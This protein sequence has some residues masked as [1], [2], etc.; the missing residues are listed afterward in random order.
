MP[1]FAGAVT[2]V[3][4]PGV[5]K[6][7]SGKVRE[8]FD[9]GSRLLMVA[10]DRVSAFDVVM[11]NGIP[12][13]GKVLNQLS[14]FWFQ[15]L[16]DICPNHMISVDDREIERAVGQSYSTAL[17]GRSMLVERGTPLPI[18]CVAR[19]YIA[20]SLYK[21]YL[22]AG[23]VDREVQVHG[24]G[25]PKG[26]L[27]G[28][29]LPKPVFTPATKAVEGHDENISQEQAAEIVGGEIAADCEA[30]TLRLFAAAS[31]VCES[32]G[33]L[34]A[35]TKFEFSSTGSDRAVGRLM[36]IDEALTPDSS[37]FWP[38]ATYAPGR[39]QESLDKQFIRDYLEGL[40]WDKTPPGPDLPDRVIEES[41]SRYIDIFRRITGSEP[42][43]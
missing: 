11:P 36:L 32:A 27:L 9:L 30:I 26:L 3:E 35:D 29:R 41:R 4:I 10:T 8:V 2:Q 39:A 42:N 21:E 19:G 12:D 31:A 23:G 33:I 40:D 38:S 28:S 15:K 18:E 37:R 24:V 25:Y 17:K 6:L 43:L 7:R 16:S 34:L 14:A 20:G 22:L 5:N 1:A 13:K